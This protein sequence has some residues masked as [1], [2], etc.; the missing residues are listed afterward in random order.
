M[1]LSHFR[2]PA[3]TS[4]GRAKGAR[5]AAPAGNP[6]TRYPGSSN[7]LVR[8]INQGRLD[9]EHPHIAPRKA[10]QIL[11]TNPE[12][13][14]G[15]Q[16]ETAGRL[17][18]ACPEMKALTTLIG[19]FA[20]MLDPGPANQDRLLEW[21]ASARP[22]DL[23]HP[24]SFTRGLEL[25]IKAA[26]AAVTLPYH[27]GR[28]EGVNNKTKMIKRQMCGRAGFELLRHRILLG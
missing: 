1:A 8:Y 21:I 19:K 9:T 5:A 28:T 24:H 11:L 12:N 16:R 6:G 7:L 4:G 2:L 18:A 3:Q 10:T 15:D 20:A 25:D 22:A 23:P 14:P 26:P 13:L 17:S 27:N